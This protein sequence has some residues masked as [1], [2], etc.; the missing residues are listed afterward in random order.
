P[1]LRRKIARAA[2]RTRARVSPCAFVRMRSLDA[3][4][5]GTPGGQKKDPSWLTGRRSRPRAAKAMPNLGCVWTTE[6]TS[7]RARMSS[8]WIERRRE[9]PVS[10]RGVGGRADARLRHLERHDLRRFGGG[11]VH[12]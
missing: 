3:V 8:V 2:P 10:T 9:Q 6:S 7:G 11:A 12:G 5:V 4:Y 1:W